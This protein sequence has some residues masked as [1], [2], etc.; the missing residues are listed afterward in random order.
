MSTILYK[1]CP[2]PLA[3][4]LERRDIYVAVERVRTRCG[5]MPMKCPNLYPIEEDG[6]WFNYK[7]VVNA[8]SVL[9]VLIK[10]HYILL[11]EWSRILLW[12]W[13]R[14]LN[15]KMVFGLVSNPQTIG[16]ALC[17]HTKDRYRNVLVLPNRGGIIR[18]IS[19]VVQFMY[20]PMLWLYGCLVKSMYILQILQAER[21]ISWKRYSEVAYKV[22]I[23]SSPGYSSAPRGCRCSN[24]NTKLLSSRWLQLD[25]HR[26]YQPLGLQRTAPQSETNNPNIRLQT[27]RNKLVQILRFICFEFID[28][29][30]FGID[31]KR[32]DWTTTTYIQT[33]RTQCCTLLTR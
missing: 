24:V 16:T 21:T 15:L 30:S 1:N 28:A 6:S 13:S 3:E 20:F 8:V 5:L 29:R 25:R 7:Y 11:W 2:C 26:P 4:W 18:Q 12:E 22:I 31:V 32:E 33:T 9:R 23:Y 27:I 14:I 19:A 17:L 10:I